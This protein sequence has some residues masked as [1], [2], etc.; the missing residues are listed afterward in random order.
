MQV[1]AG[2]IGENVL[3][4][5][6]I[7]LNKLAAPQLY[8]G[9][10]GAYLSTWAVVMST[11]PSGGFTAWDIIPLKVTSANT[12]SGYLP[13]DSNLRRI[14]D[15]YAAAK[16]DMPF[17]IIFGA[18]PVV[19]L[20][21][22]FKLKRGDSV[23]PEIAGGLQRQPLQMVKSVTSDLLI[24][25]TAEMVIEGVIKPGEILPGTDAE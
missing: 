17:A 14:H 21:A 20:V 23:A 9:D 22:A 18:Q 19:P 7:N 10:D 15:L 6:D 3:Q 11:E 25:A 4:G 16:K 5:K 1:D 24:P 2:P 8:D 12:L 13:K